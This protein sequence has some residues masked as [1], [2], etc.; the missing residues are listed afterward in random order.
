MK[1][2]FEQLKAKLYVRHRDHTFKQFGSNPKKVYVNVRTI[3]ASILCLPVVAFSLTLLFSSVYLLVN[4]NNLFLTVI[5]VA[6]LLALSVLSVPINRR[7]KNVCYIVPS[8][9]ES[10]Y[11]KVNEVSRVIGAKSI[12][13]I[14]FDSSFNANYTNRFFGRRRQVVLGLPLI[15]ALQNDEVTALVA[16]EIAHSIADDPQ[17]TI[18]ISS[19]IAGLQGL[20]NMMIGYIES[21]ERHLLLFDLM[22]WLIV[23]LAHAYQYGILLLLWQDSRRSEFLADLNA[24]SATTNDAMV[25]LLRK[26]SHSEIVAEMIQESEW[27]NQSFVEHYKT[28]AVSKL[29]SASA[30]WTAN[31]MRSDATT[32]PVVDDR[33]ALVQRTTNRQRLENHIG[34]DLKAT[35]IA[36]SEPFLQEL[37]NNNRS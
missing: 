32:Y 28:N 37:Y 2:D 15:L 36:M 20:K 9:H 11:R 16:H 12:D 26:V 17:K 7:K 13:R 3:F 33:I 6:P 18:V 29:V 23:Y 30:T 14:G 5:F 24:L 21:G 34:A 27:A 8:E 4:S 35:A 10:L 31:A 19:G 22:C 25:R 1:F